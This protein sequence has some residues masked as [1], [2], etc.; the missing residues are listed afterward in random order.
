MAG[1]QGDAVHWVAKP[2]ALLPP[3]YRS[4]MHVHFSGNLDDVIA[5]ME[6]LV[7][8]NRSREISK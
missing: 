5:V 4:D 2:G 7:S 3:G 8:E 6:L 1:G